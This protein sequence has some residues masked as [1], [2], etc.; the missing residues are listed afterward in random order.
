KDL[1][2]SGH[3]MLD[4]QPLLIADIEG[5]HPLPPAD[6]TDKP[7]FDGFGK[8]G[9]LALAPCPNPPGTGCP[10]S[11]LSP[12]SLR[13]FLANAVTDFLS[14]GMNQSGVQAIAMNDILSHI[15]S[16]SN[17]LFP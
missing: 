2:T 3:H 4:L 5:G 8:A 9:Q 13:T 11:T 16:D 7:L 12:K 14:H 17:E 10:L 6:Q 1:H 15:T